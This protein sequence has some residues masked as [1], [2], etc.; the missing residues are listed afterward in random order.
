VNA[1]RQFLIAAGAWVLAASP[2]PFAQKPG[3]VYRVGW[4]SAG[5]AAGDQEFIEALKKVLSDLGYADGTSIVFDLRSAEGRPERTAALAAELVALKPDL[6]ITGATPGT[7]AAKQATT[8]IPLLMIGVSDPVGAGFVASL[9]HPGGNITGVANMGL[10]MA[11]KPLELLHAVVP[12]ATRIAVLRSDNPAITAIIGKIQEAAKGLGLTVTPI[13][14]KTVDEIESAFSSMTKGKA[15]ALIVIADSVTMVN[16][17][18]IA[19]L[20]AEA[21]LPAI[22]QYLAQ[23]EAGGLFSYGPNPHDLDKVVAGYIDKIL[24]GAKPGDL[25]VQQPTE[26]ELAINM[27]AAKALGIKFPPEILLRADKVIP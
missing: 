13:T 8:T 10:D 2:A 27:K 16:R 6:I 9:A 19:E 7:R 23:V 5:T 25:P 14:V 18:R 4:L 24:K 21:K 12:T 1:R 22:Y 3:R 11:A 26:F 15:E 17:V 20:A